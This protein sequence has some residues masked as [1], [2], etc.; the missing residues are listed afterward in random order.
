MKVGS[1]WSH[2]ETS[3]ATPCSLDTIL[4]EVLPFKLDDVEAAI[5]HIIYLYNK[6]TPRVCK[7]WNDA[8]YTRAHVPQ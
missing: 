1:H 7:G 3:A 4:N 5:A 8:Q 6:I 2:S